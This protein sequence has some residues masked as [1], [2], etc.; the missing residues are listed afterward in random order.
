MRQRVDEFHCAKRARKKHKVETKPRAML[1]QDL[2]SISLMDKHITKCL[3]G[4]DYEYNTSLRVIGAALHMAA[5]GISLE[6]AEGGE[7]ESQ[8]HGEAIDQRHGLQSIPHW[9]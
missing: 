9:T 7:G 2:R 4:Q 6:G 8:V 1:P 5:K 3:Y